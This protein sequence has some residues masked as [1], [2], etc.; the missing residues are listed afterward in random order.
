[1]WFS[2]SHGV[3]VVVIGRPGGPIDDAPCYIYPHDHMGSNLE[4]HELD[5]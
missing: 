1:M 4:V 3:S 2:G 5:N